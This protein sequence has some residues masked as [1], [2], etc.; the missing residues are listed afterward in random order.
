MASAVPQCHSIVKSFEE[1]FKQHIATFEGQTGFLPFSAWKKGYSVLLLEMFQ[2]LANQDDFWSTRMDQWQHGIKAIYNSKTSSLPSLTRIVL[3]RLSSLANPS[4][5]ASIDWE[6]IGEIIGK[7]LSTPEILPVWEELLSDRLLSPTME[8]TSIVSRQQEV[9]QRSVESSSED[10]NSLDDQSDSESTP[11]K[12]SAR[13]GKNTCGNIYEG[14][15]LGTDCYL[16]NKRNK[17]NCIG[18]GLHEMC[19]TCVHFMEH[20]QDVIDHPRIQSRSHCVCMWPG[21]G[22]KMCSRCAW[23]AEL[24]D[25]IAFPC[26]ICEVNHGKS[27]ICRYCSNCW[28][29]CT[30][31]SPGTICPKCKDNK[32]DVKCDYCWACIECCCCEEDIQYIFDA[33]DETIYGYEMWKECTRDEFAYSF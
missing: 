8:T 23:E 2:S 31:A 20:C 24:V 26:P 29:H 15:K 33:Y 27:L 9:T 10:S 5:T 14:P 7:S 28:F 22:L 4:S 11:N 6:T 25:V 32:D 30:C 1:H 13:H 21:G 17:C 12:R 3:S 19:T 18:E 16:F